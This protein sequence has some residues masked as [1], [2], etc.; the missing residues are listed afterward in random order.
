[1]MH[2]YYVLSKA[3][4]YA[5]FYVFYAWIFFF[6]LQLLLCFLV[7]RRRFLKLIPAIFLLTEWVDIAIF[8]FAFDAS[9]RGH[10]G[11]TSAALSRLVGMSC[12][13][14]LCAWIVY[15][16]FY[17]GKTAWRKIEK[18]KTARQHG[19]SKA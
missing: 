8:Y 10:G 19:K 17:A 4:I 6:L 3:Y 12:T 16:L 2:C 13:A 18:E 1:M 14:V 15:G 7:S 11:E 9:V 5:D